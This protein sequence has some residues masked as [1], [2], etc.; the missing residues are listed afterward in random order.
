MDMALALVA[1]LCGIE[2]ARQAALWAEYVWN[3]DREN[4]PF[5]HADDC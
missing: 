3:E 2:R 1:R 5:T 4:D